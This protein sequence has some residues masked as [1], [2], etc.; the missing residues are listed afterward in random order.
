MSEIIRRTCEE[1]TQPA[2]GREIRYIVVHYTSRSSS[3]PGTAEAVAREFA[4]PDLL[5]S[6]DFVV[7]DGCAVQY[8]PDPANS[9]C[10]HCGGTKVAASSGGSFYKVCTNANSVGVELCSENSSGEITFANDPRYS[11]SDAVLDRAAALIGS[12]MDQ[13]GIDVSHVVR[14]YDVTGKLCPGVIGWNEDSGDAEQWYAFRRECEKH[15]KLANRESGCT[16][17]GAEVLRLLEENGIACSAEDGFAESVFSSLAFHS[18][19]AVPGTLFFC[20]GERFRP[21]YLSAAVKRGAAGYLSENRMDAEIPGL[22]VSNVKAAMGLVSRA[23]YGDPQKKLVTVGVTGTNGK[24][25]VAHFIAHILEEACGKR[26][27]LL[28]TVGAYDGRRERELTLTT[29]EATVTQSFLHETLRN[30]GTHF[31]MECSS[32]GEKMKRLTGL[33]FDVGVFTN[34]SDDHYSPRE[35]ASFEEYLA[36]KL[37]IVRRYRNAVINADDPRCADFVKAAASAER[38]VTYSL[39]PDAGADVYAESVEEM[40]LCPVFTAVTP[41]W[42][43]RI[44]VPFPGGFN[45]SNALA[46]CA[47]G[48]LLGLPPEA[49]AAGIEKTFIHGR[50]FVFDQY[51]YAVV[52]DYAHNYA[53]VRAALEAVRELYP[54]KRIQ[55]V[56]GGTGSTGLQRRRDIVRAAAP[57]CEKLYVT[58]EDPHD[59]DPNEIISEIA[60]HAREAGADYEVIPDR[61]ECIETAIRRMTEDNVL[62]ITAK[63]AEAFIKVGGRRVYYEGDPSVVWRMLD[64]KKVYDRDRNDF[65]SW[66]TYDEVYNQ[67]AAWPEDEFPDAPSPYFSKI[68]CYVTSLAI[69]LR[70]SG[71]VTE[72]SFEKF[73]PLILHE[74]LKAAHAYDTEGAVDTASLPKVCPLRIVDSVPY[75]REKLIRSLDEGYA[76]QIMVTGRNARYHYVVPVRV[77]EDDV[78]IIDCA[79]DKTRLSELEPIWIARYLPVSSDAP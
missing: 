17:S 9:F 52:V 38:I 6:A 2:P 61:T 46:A 41:E 43:Q 21:D 78:E 72:P 5:V 44:T 19:G 13:Y 7:D 62:F 50:M 54:N 37:D 79:W 35:H 42:K 48:Y 58:N 63:G 15:S 26:P 36:C 53:S 8:N 74:Q 75:T 77:L 39:S 73:N 24:T 20:K 31:V 1:N 45:I 4:D 59:A 69:L 47:A 68:G 67:T 34:I 3:K 27:G 16:L 14:H 32:Q 23:F 51:G 60:A 40:G 10:W 12:L 76:C 64:E 11:F 71:L 57:L 49:I 66:R 29:P 18:D 70:Q 22:T 25:T 33:Q 30:G 65:R 28:S 56:F 55:I